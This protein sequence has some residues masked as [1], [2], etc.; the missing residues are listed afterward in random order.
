MRITDLLFLFVLSG[1]QVLAEKS[2][3]AKVLKLDFPMVRTSVEIP[4]TAAGNFVLDENKLITTTLENFKAP[5]SLEKEANALGY[6]F[7][8]PGDGK[9]DKTLEQ[10]PGYEL[11]ILPWGAVY[12]WRNLRKGTSFYT[13]ACRTA[14]S[15]CFRIG[16]YSMTTFDWKKAKFTKTF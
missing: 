4:A 13:Y 6:T 16:P 9:F 11:E 2:P 3:P 15:Y 5:E 8:R 12:T 14:D 1:T 10:I 7:L